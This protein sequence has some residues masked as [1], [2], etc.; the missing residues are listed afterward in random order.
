MARTLGDSAILNPRNLGI[1]GPAK[2]AVG[3]VPRLP[4]V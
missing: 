2:L 1:L 4:A 3:F